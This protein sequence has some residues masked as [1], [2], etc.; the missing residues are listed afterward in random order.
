MFFIG[1]FQCNRTEFAVRRSYLQ[2]LW[3]AAAFEYE[4]KSTSMKN[5]FVPRT[6]YSDGS[7]RS[8]FISKFGKTARCMISAPDLVIFYGFYG[9]SL[10]VT[11]MEW[12]ANRTG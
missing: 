9:S 1:I 7:P 5:G 3:T 6:T 4:I 10:I 2:K 11:F 8:I 12:T